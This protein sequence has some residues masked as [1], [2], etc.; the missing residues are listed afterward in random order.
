MSEQ[1]ENLQGEVETTIPAE[2]A[3][4]IDCAECC[5]TIE[6][7]R[8]NLWEAIDAAES[9]AHNLKALLKASK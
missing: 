6:D 5:E 1:L 3:D 8:A 7:F 4:H 9:L 2:I